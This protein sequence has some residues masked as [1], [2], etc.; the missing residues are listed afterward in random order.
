MD[1]LNLDTNDF[2]DEKKSSFIDEDKF[3]P[4][5]KKGKGGVYSAVIRFLPWWKDPKNS[6]YKK[7]VSILTHPLSK[8]KLFI[9]CPSTPSIGKSSILFTLQMLLNRMEK[10]KIDMDVVNE[11][12]KN[13]TRYYNYF[14]PVYIIKDPQNPELNDQVKI[15]PYGS[16]IEK[17]Q[18]ALL[19]PAKIDGDIPGLEKVNP[20]SLTEGRDFLLVLRKGS[21]Y[22]QDYD[23]CKFI[24]KNTP[25]R[26]KVGDKQ[27]VCSTPATAEDA[28]KQNALISKYLEKATPDLE[29]YYAKEWTDDDYKNV[30]IYIKAIVGPY[31]NLMND[32]INN[33]KDEKM[34]ALLRDG[35]SEAVTPEIKTE[36]KSEKS[37]TK[38][39]DD[40]LNDLLNDF[41]EDVKEDTKVEES[42]ETKAEVSESSDDDFDDLLSGL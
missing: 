23:Q 16:I 21:S 2:V 28:K 24:E 4:H 41:D 1:L 25:F 6:K 15:Y 14:S 35:S 27:H 36:A 30:A 33:S 37:D 17:L 29:K 12:K 39:D 20:F 7:Y 18:E 26:F 22:G 13:F 11:V 5:Q 19:N 40:E 9:D 42:V 32:L 10:E 34:N 8:E 31:K 38:V 3:S